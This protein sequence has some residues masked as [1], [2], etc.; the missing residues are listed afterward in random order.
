MQEY[1]PH[2]IELRKRIIRCGVV[3]LSF[4]A[5]FFYFD[6]K[7]YYIIALPLLKNLPQTGQLVSLDITSTFTVP[8][9]LALIS[10]CVV[11]APYGFFQLWS[12]AAPGLYSHEKKTILPFL[13][14]SI[15]LFYFGIVFNFLIL[16]PMAITFFIKSAPHNVVIMTDM[17]YYLDFIL[18]ILFS[19]GLAFQVPV[20]TLALIQFNLVTTTFLTHLRPYI[21]VLVFIVGMLLTPPDVVS[22]ILLAL[23]MWGLFELGLFIGKRIERTNQIEKIQKKVIIQ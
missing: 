7:L 8:M 2:L 23:P 10:A 3:L 22:Q 13:I 14:S 4:F 1:I 19:G 12:F 6:E 11:T 17:R 21:I 20:I 16:A 15:L 9:K 18:T 5:V